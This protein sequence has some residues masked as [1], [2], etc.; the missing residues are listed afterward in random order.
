MGRIQGRG[1]SGRWNSR[2]VGRGLEWGSLWGPA[3]DVGELIRGQRRG[4]SGRTEVTHPLGVGR[5]T[6]GGALGATKRPGALWAG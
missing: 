1:A 3:G 4:S 5:A 2:R 6:W